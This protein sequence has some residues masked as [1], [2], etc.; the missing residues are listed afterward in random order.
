MPVKS[1]LL[2]SYWLLLDLQDAPRGNVA[3]QC[4]ASFISQVLLIVFMVLEQIFILYFVQ[5]F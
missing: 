4:R 3:P 2:S 5:L 1:A